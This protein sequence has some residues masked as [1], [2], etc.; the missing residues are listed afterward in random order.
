M[1]LC[2]EQ[3]PT[4]EIEVRVIVGECEADLI[5]ALLDSVIA[6]ARLHERLGKRVRKTHM[7]ETGHTGALLCL[8]YPWVASMHQQLCIIS[9][10]FSV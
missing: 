5:D 9:C 1:M 8:A 10:E 4:T 3:A 6:D 7:I 2:E